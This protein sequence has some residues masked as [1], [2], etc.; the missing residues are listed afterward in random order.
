MAA[1]LSETQLDVALASSPFR[2]DQPA[3]FSWLGVSIYLTR[4]A[5]LAT[6]GAIASSA[7]A[8]S[9]LVFEYV[10]QR[11]LD[12]LPEQG[13]AQEA[14]ARVASAGEPWISGFDPNELVGDLRRT[15]LEPI[16]NLGPEELG[17]RYCADRTDGLTPSNGAYIAH[18][19][20]TT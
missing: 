4:T 3:F 6:L 13:P 20:V 10:D 2:N 9:E 16:E 14:R 18:A 15:G 5:N 12:S 7:H 8:G 1:D 19:R 11:L 17:A